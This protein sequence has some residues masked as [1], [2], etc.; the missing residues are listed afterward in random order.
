MVN[1]MYF[2]KRY[3]LRG[4]LHLHS[5]QSDGHLTIDSVV[6][7]YAQAGYDFIALSDHWK[8][9]LAD[10]HAPTPLVVLNGAELDGFD[11]L[12]SYYHVLAI[13]LRQQVSPNGVIENA[14]AAA[15]EQGALLFLAHPHWT[16]NSVE[17]GLRHAFDGMEIYNHSSQCE[18]G[19]GSAGHYWDT[20]LEHRANFTGIA[21]DDAHFSPGE[22]FWKGGWIMVNSD[23]KRAS[24]IVAAIR[25]S[26]FYATQGPEFHSFT[27]TGNRIEMEMTPVKFAR[28]VGPRNMGKWVYQAGTLEMASFELPGNWPWVRLE[29]EDSEGHRAWTNAL[30][31]LAQ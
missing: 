17:E 25:Q 5:D 2:K 15:R 26:N 21:V 4:N 12:G 16:G 19:K 31:L 7:K 13:G 27:R 28:L 11:R 8:T 24:D 3:W 10:T 6:R 9:F 1:N 18:T 14:L 23:R 29:I 22:P 20:I 30:A